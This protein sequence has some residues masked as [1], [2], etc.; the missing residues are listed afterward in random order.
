MRT[1][2]PASAFYQAT[3]EANL[4]GT[5]PTRWQKRAQR[6]MAPR[7]TRETVIAAVLGDTRDWLSWLLPLDDIKEKGGITK[8]TGPGSA[9]YFCYCRR[10]AVPLK[11]AQHCQAAADD[12]PGDVVM[13]VKESLAS[14]DLQQPVVTLC[15]AGANWQLGRA[16]SVWLART[17]FIRG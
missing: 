14:T 2:T 11:F 6:Y 15:R 4:P 12:L 1:S 10:R 9:R 17:P 5:R 16:P 8:L 7:L 3:S 13:L